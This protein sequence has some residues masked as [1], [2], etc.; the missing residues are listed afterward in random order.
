MEIAD[1]SSSAVK[2]WFSGKNDPSCGSY[3]S[4]SNAKSCDQGFICGS[5]TSDITGD[6]PI[7]GSYAG[8][9]TSNILIHSK[10][11]TLDL[12]VTDRGSILMRV[13]SLFD[14]TSEASIT[15]K[16]GGIRTWNL[17]V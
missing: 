12:I 16:L 11:S 5:V 6:V 3:P 15:E 13:Y 10:Y 8:E 7:I 1:D 9:V 2:N 4:T 14:L 17:P